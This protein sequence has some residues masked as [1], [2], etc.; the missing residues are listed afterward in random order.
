MAD[1]TALGAAVR[2]TIAMETAAATA[3][4]FP[5]VR[6]TGIDGPA[7]ACEVPRTWIPPVRL[8]G[9]RKVD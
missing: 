5:A 6:V 1:E 4:T 9:G 7:D 2:L 3:R 8:Y